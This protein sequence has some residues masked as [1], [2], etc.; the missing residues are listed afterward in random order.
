MVTLVAIVTLISMVT[1]YTCITLQVCRA[2]PDSVL[3]L[4]QHLRDHLS[5]G[6]F[7]CDKCSYIALSRQD[8]TAHNTHVHSVVSSVIIRYY[9]NN[10]VLH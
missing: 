4:R 6:A 9:T 3:A 1:A 8:L 5:A 2:R 10:T 7:L